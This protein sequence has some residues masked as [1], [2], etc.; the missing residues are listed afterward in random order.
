MPKEVISWHEQVYW[1]NR[2]VS[3]VRKTKQNHFKNEIAKNRKDCRDIWDVLRNVHSVN[4]STI[5]QHASYKSH[6][7]S[8]AKI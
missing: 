1:R 3:L 4:N 6:Q 2:V 5:S 8:I 7:S